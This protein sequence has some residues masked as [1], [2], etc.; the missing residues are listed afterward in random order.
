[1]RTYKKITIPETTENKL[2]SIFCDICGEKKTREFYSISD[3]TVSYKSGFSYP[4]S[5]SSREVSY[6]IC[7]NCFTSKLVPWLESQG[8]TNP[9]V[10]EEY[11]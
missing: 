11:W 2:D 7:S 6:D 4:D 3:V 1:M 5:G 10:E 9:Q 8:A